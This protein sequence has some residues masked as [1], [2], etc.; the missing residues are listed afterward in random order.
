MT[1]RTADRIRDT[2]TTTGTGSLTISGTGPVGYR[3]FS[4]ITSITTNDT[5]LCLTAHQTANEWE[6]GLYTYTNSTTLART[7]I[8]ASS[9]AGSA[10]S[11][12][13]GTK[14]V[15]L[16]QTA[17]REVLTTELQVPKLTGGDAASS[18][19]TIQSTSGAGTS[20]AINF[21]T[22]SQ[23]TRMTIDTTG[24]V[25]IN[26]SGANV[27]PLA[28]NQKG[29]KY[30]NFNGLDNSQ[31]IGLAFNPLNGSGVIKSTVLYFDSSQTIF[32]GPPTGLLKFGVDNGSGSFNQ[33][34]TLES[35]TATYAVFGSA[36][37]RGITEAGPTTVY[38]S[39]E[40]QHTTNTNWSA[41]FLG[42]GSG[43]SNPGL[44]FYMTR[45]STVASHIS[46]ALHDQDS[47]FSIY[48]YG[49]DGTA[50]I[51]SGGIASFVD[52]TPATGTVK[53]FISFFTSAGSG[54]INERLRIG[55]GGVIN[56]GG[57]GAPVNTLFSFIPD[58]ELQ[59]VGGGHNLARHGWGSGCSDFWCYSR[60]TT[61]NSF[62]AVQS[63]DQLMVLY[64]AG[65]DGSAWVEAASIAVQVDGSVSGGNVPGRIVFRTTS[66]ETERMRIANAGNI[67]VQGA[68]TTATP[69]NA[70][71]NSGSTPVNELLRS[72]SSLRYK[73]KVTPVPQSRIKA[74]MG[75][76]P[77]EYCSLA[78]AD[79]P[80][81]RFIG[82]AAED[83]AEVDP[84]LV[85]HDDH[86]RPDGVMYDRVLL[87]Q[88]AALTQRIIELEARMAR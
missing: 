55:S 15:V 47:P 72:T 71:I 70:F 63:A 51:L 4:S 68:G 33:L 43:P 2:T 34:F 44:G 85:C 53:S 79:D 84:Q 76:Q 61:V 35:G 81:A 59:K 54:A 17:E 69:A 75:L 64:A 18:A 80:E 87:L 45:A 49:D 78:K 13:A 29:L 74:I 5:F 88:V 11:F 23:S 82:F 27:N 16:V 46:G 37:K 14:D 12:S 56:T 6:V 26:V 48:W 41:L 36:A 66:S 10:V 60:G 32:Q 50:D 86:G 73:T 38:A 21:L 62:T 52:G 20:D 28:I 40:A 30:V 3:S 65:S 25:L 42:Y 8:L 24:Q 58:M 19:L 77:I 83:V 22:G 1:L 31:G 39:I 7:T 57:G 67:Y 9:N